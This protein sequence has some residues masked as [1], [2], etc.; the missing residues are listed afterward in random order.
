[1]RHCVMHYDILLGILDLVD[2]A[3]DYLN[4]PLNRLYKEQ[5]LVQ[6]SSCKY[7]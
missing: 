7:V 5:Q 6:F 1:M 4:K 2:C 3:I